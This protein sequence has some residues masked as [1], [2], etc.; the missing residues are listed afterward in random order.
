MRT[1]HATRG[2]GDNR[3]HGMHYM[4][5]AALAVALPGAG[6]AEAASAAKPLAAR[7]DLNKFGSVRQMSADAAVQDG[8]KAASKSPRESARRIP[9]A[10]LSAIAAGLAMATSA[11]STRAS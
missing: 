4:L 2:A 3:R 10:R 1:S 9:T 11:H 5:A 6:A 8:A 7:P